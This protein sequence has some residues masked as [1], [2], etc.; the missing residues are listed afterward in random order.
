MCSISAGRHHVDSPPARHRLGGAAQSGLIMLENDP[1]ALPLV[2]ATG[3][4]GSRWQLQPL[5]W[6]LSFQSV[7]RV[8]IVVRVRSDARDEGR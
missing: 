5:A 4:E 8:V 2:G 3:S 6:D 7:S 1:R